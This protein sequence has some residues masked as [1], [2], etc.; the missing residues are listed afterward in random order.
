MKRALSLPA[1][2]LIKPPCSLDSINTMPVSP[3]RSAEVC[4]TWQSST[5]TIRSSKKGRPSW[6]YKT[7]NSQTSFMKWTVWSW[8]PS[9]PALTWRITWS[10]STRWKYR[11]Q[12]LINF[13]HVALYYLTTSL[14]LTIAILYRHSIIPRSMTS[15]RESDR[16]LC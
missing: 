2:T 1:K 13:Q 12:S 16:V 14:V 15:F 10:L 6:R 8:C 3:N 5:I 11:T 7:V 4:S 9:L